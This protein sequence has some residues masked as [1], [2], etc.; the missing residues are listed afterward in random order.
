MKI[1]ILATAALTVLLSFSAFSSDNNWETLSSE[2]EMTGDFSAYA[3]SPRVSPLKP[4]G[5]PYGDV[6]SWLGVGCNSESSWVYIG[7]NDTP[8]ISR[9]ETGDGYNYIKARVKWDVDVV[10]EVLTQEWGSRF[11][12]FKKDKGVLSRIPSSKKIKVELYWYKHG[13]QYFEYDLSGSGSSIE[14]IL[15]QL[16]L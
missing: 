9:D 7:F 13:K 1:S 4:M 6:S 10:E 5:F 3:S 14:K 15:A 11:I 12:H 2:D 16:N 8:N